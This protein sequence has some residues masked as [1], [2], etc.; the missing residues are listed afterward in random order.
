[1]ASREDAICHCRLSGLGP[2]CPRLA[3]WLFQHQQARVQCAGSGVAES[4]LRGAQALL[5]FLFNPAVYRPEHSHQPQRRSLESPV[6][7]STLPAS[8]S[9]FGRGR[10]SGATGPGMVGRTRAGAN[11]SLCNRPTPEYLIMQRGFQ[12]V[13]FVADNLGSTLLHCHCHQQRRAGIN[14]YPQ[15]MSCRRD[16]CRDLLRPDTL[17]RY[18]ARC[19]HAGSPWPGRDRPREQKALPA[20]C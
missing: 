14:R 2:R 11:R 16:V 1:V 12:E 3:A 20:H 19:N 17:A 18:D 8:P 13:D 9:P 6:L 5:C 10:R 7:C 4:P 15:V